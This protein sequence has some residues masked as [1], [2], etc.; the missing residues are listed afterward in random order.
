M[1]EKLFNQINQF[2]IVLTGQ[3]NHLGTV[4]IDFQLYFFPI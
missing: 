3:K 4:K 1:R 2:T